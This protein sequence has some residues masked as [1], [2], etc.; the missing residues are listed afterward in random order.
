MDNLV[1]LGRRVVLVIFENTDGHKENKVSSC[2][3]TTLINTL[4]A[5]I[6]TKTLILHCRHSRPWLG[7]HEMVRSW[8]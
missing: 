4:M 7:T 2:K 6:Q 1:Y 5:E 8:S 3:L